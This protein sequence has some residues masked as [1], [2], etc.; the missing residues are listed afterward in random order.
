MSDTQERIANLE[1]RVEGALAIDARLKAC[2]TQ[3]Q[4]LDTRLSELKHVGLRNWLQALG[5]FASS[6]A[7]LLIG[8]WVTD[9]VK[10]AL[11]REQLDLDYVKDMRDLIKDFDESTTPPAADANAIALA[12]YGRHAILP[13]VQRLEGGD[14]VQLAA[15]KALVLVGSNDP[16]AACPKFAAII[17]D[18]A[19]RFRWQTH[20]TILRVMGQSECVKSLH[21]VTAYNSQLGAVGSGAQALDNFAKRYSN[22]AGF[23]GESLAV[24]QEQLKTT[25]DIL[26]PTVQP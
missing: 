9:S 25:L 19:R 8:Y 15:E 3:L 16:A 18:K 6:V 14:V 26:N 21:D 12:M 24:L 7:L 2:D 13:L 10:S 17:N 1:A 23:D 22:P 20:Q 5:P 11:E 4:A